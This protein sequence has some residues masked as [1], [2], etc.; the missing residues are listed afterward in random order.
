M[1]IK[2]KSG[3]KTFCYSSEFGSVCKICDEGDNRHSVS[4]I[5]DGRRDTWWQSPS[6]HEGDYNWV[7]ITINLNEVSLPLTDCQNY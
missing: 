5:L 4:D 6:M 7:T 2:G 1:W 3:P